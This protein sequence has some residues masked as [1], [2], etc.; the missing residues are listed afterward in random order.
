MSAVLQ[1]MEL[2]DEESA[3]AIMP[4]PMATKPTFPYGLCITLTGDELDKLGLDHDDAKVGGMFM[5]SA[6]ARITSVSTSE[7][8]DNCSCRVEAQIEAMCVDGS[9]PDDAPRPATRAS[10]LYAG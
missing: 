7:G 8:E 10:R 1:S 4:I 2:D 6:M 5:F 9:E 3:D